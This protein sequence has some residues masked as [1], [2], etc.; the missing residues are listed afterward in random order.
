MSTL[1][2]NIHKLMKKKSSGMV[3]QFIRIIKGF[4]RTFYSCLYEQLEIKETKLPYAVAIE[5]LIWLQIIF[6]PFS[7][8]FH[9]I[10]RFDKVVY[11]IWGFS[12]YLYLAPALSLHASFFVYTVVHYVILFLGAFMVVITVL[13]AHI[14]SFKNIKKYP[15]VLFGKLWFR[16]FPL[17]LVPLLDFNLVSVNCS[18]NPEGLLAM[19]FYPEHVCWTSD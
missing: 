3:S 7:A 15:F 18:A 19:T 1:R 2:Q 11:Y 10:W 4:K 16:V 8:T 13:I 6:A 12:N 5:A 17:L 14:K 9:P